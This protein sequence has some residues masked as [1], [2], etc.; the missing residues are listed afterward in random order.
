MRNTT[1]R[2][3]T[4][5]ELR[6]AI[7]DARGTPIS[8]RAIVVLPTRQTALEPGESISVRILLEGIRP[9]T[10]RS[11]LLMEVTGLRFD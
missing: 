7:L 3:L 8:E 5:L 4:G 6:G 2:A 9:E 1:D 11:G 10:E